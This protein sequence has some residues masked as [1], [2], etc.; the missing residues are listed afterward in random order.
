MLYFLQLQDPDRRRSALPG[1]FSS[2]EIDLARSLDLS[3]HQ[4]A[5]SVALGGDDCDL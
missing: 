4:T 2:S 3:P 5:S 1:G